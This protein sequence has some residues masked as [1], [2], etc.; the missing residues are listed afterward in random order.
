MIETYSE[1]IKWIHSRLR[2]G[3]KPG[4]KRMEWMMEKLGHPESDVQ[5]VHIGGTNGK[6]S[7]VSYL[8]SILTQAGYSVGTFTSPYFEQFN[9][10]ISVNGR[11]LPDED[12]VKLVNIIQPLACQLEDTELGSPTEFE[13]ITAM[14]IYY[15]SRLNP[16]DIVIMEVGL[17]GRF[18]STNVIKP[19]ISGITNIGFDHMNILGSTIGEIAFEKAGIIKK[20]TP[21]VTCAKQLEALKVIKSKAVEENA[22]LICFSDDFRAAGHVSTEGGEKFDFSFKEISYDA[23]EISMVGK[24]QVE[25]ASMAVMISILLDG[26]A[27]FRI[28]EMDVRTG[29]ADAFW[30]GR[31]EKLSQSPLIY[32]DGAHNLDGIIALKNTI[33]Q[34]FSHLNKKIVFAALKDKEISQMIA[35]L[36]GLEGNL[37]FT[38]FDFPRAATAMELY[39]KSSSDQ[40]TYGEDWMSVVKDVISGS[41]ENDVIIITG[42]LYFLSA[43]KPFYLQFSKNK[44]I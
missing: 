4:L 40:K 18:D 30:P 32:M 31:M 7:T 14:A 17:G 23:L 15:F 16:Q 8:R 36:D 35:A 28:K 9:E 44:D 21:I 33:Q 2:L 26:H 22:E 13:V 6:G 25:N 42:S 3:I 10:R 37:Y 1:A 43:V 24:H 29:L 12:L 34:R 19:L 41:D 39:E 11:P 5:F 38:Q 27:S 20:D